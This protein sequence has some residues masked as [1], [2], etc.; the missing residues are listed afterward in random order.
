M[1][2]IAT[3]CIVFCFIS[4]VY[5]EVGPRHVE[6]EGGF[7]FCAPKGWEFKEYPGMKFKIAFGISKDNF[8]PNI[9]AV[10]EAYAGSLST[11]IDM[12]IATMKKM[13]QQFKK[14]KRVKFKTSSKL[15]GEFLVINSLQ[16]GNHLRQSF[17]FIQGNKGKNLVITCSCLEKDGDRFSKLFEESLKTVELM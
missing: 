13:F 15:N 6:K 7:S 11:Y 12:N 8:C 3:I 5:S 2:A 9:N 17:L 16:Q 10:D 4:L 1:K 14:I